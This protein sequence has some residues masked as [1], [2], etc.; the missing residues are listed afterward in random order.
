MTFEDASGYAGEAE[1]LEKPS[2][3]EEVSAILAEASKSGTPVTVLGAGTGVTGGAVPKGGLVLSLER[4]RRLDIGQGEARAGA[5]LL[6]HELQSAARKAGQFYAPDPT[7][8]AA[9]L[10]GTIANN[11][12]GSRS[13]RYGPTRRH[14]KSLLCV[15]ADGTIRELPRGE[16][17]DFPVTPVHRPETT[18]HQAGYQ[19]ADNM[20]WVDLICGSEG[21]LA[22]VVEATFNLLPAPGER[23]SGVVFFPAEG[24]AMDAIDAWRGVPELCMLEYVDE[25]SLRLIDGPKA[26]AALLIEQE[27]PDEDAWLSRMEETG[28]LEEESWFG[29]AEP[30]RERFRKF[31]HAL[32]EKVNDTV[33]KRGYMKMGT[34]YAVPIARHRDML[35]HYRESL[36]AYPGDGV[37]YGH[38]GDGHLHVNLMPANDAEKDQAW[39]MMHT[40]AAQAV[41]LGG[42]VGAEHGLG[43]RKAHL[44]K[45]M[46]SPEEIESMM[47][48]KRRLD[49]AWI[50]GR[51][52]L[53]PV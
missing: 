15:F 5:G 27:H 36:N 51:G 40:W 42:T 50:L 12:S 22:V 34:D 46:Y 44:L 43:K 38:V 31:R 10:G 21:T 17:L 52:N 29:T 32:P 45:L 53:F 26:G 39:E 23:L 18:K 30:D 49:P 37:V 7:H 8:N 6:L 3:P 14:L 19:L 11:A 25:A 28:A 20:E 9:A 24:Q 35:A 16:R 1:R 33:R 48:V 41:A 13:F 47:A 4:F 2:T